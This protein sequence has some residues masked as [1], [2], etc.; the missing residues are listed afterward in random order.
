MQ[1]RQ[2][3]AILSSVCVDSQESCVSTWG[4]DMKAQR[5][6]GSQVAKHGDRLMQFYHQR[7]LIHRRAVCPCGDW[8]WRLSSLKAHKSLNMGTDSCSFIISVCWFTRGLCVY[9]GTGHEGLAVLRLTSHW[10][11]GQTHAVLSSAC[12]DS[13]EGCVSMWGLDMKAQRS[14]KT[15]TDSCKARDLWI[16]HFVPLQL[17]N[18]IALAFTSKEIGKS[19]FVI[20]DHTLHN[21]GPQTLSHCSSL[22][23]SLCQ[24]STSKDMSVDHTLHN[25]GSHTLSTCS[26]SAR[27]LCQASTSK[28]IDRSHFMIVPMQL[29]NYITLAFAKKKIDKSHLCQCGSH[30]S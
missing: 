23:R 25:C 16:T 22:A 8:T 29:I 30:T 7:V 28:E 17:I 6:V 26:S 21:C 27:S 12:F 15:G 11:W 20:V 19:H 10:R 1:Q 3:A 4:L 5:S 14:L 24:A 2:T 9:V 13:Q 18:K